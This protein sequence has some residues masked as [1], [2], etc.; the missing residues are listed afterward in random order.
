MTVTLRSESSLMMAAAKEA[1]VRRLMD[2]L[3]RADLATMGE[4][5]SD[6]VVY[7]FPGR[8]PVSGTY[9]GRDEVLG[10]FP[11]FRRLLDAPPTSSSHD[12]V[13]SEAHVV[14]LTTLS[15]ERGGRRHEW[16]VVRI[17]HV[18]EAEIT[19]IWLMIDDIN[20]FDAW[21]AAS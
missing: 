19:E 14:E 16:N 5:V 20:A 9:R 8:G 17:Y 21:L 1:I 3:H 4:L 7:H 15:A 12:V 13:A 18:A 10:L 6:D 11:A 2:A